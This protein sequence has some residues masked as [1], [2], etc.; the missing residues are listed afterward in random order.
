VVLGE[1]H[2]RFLECTGACT[3][4]RQI[5][6]GSMFFAL[7]GPNFNANALAGEAL[8]EGCRYS[9]VDDPAVA[10]DDRYVLVGDVLSTLQALAHLHRMRFDVPVL[11]I[12]GT[13]GKTTT[14][15]LVHVVMGADRPTLAT[16]GNLN[17]HIG[18]PLTLLRLKRSTGSRSS[19]WART[20]PVTSRS[21]VPS[22]G[23]RMR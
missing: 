4:T 3:D 1:I 20:S 5:V 8:K 11:G 21:F 18:V 9:V 6:P 10:V 17:N 22:H 13:N 14:K 15:E 16:S 12:T 2:K 19:K 7:K 23:P